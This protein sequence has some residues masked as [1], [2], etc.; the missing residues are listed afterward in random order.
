MKKIHVFLEH[1]VDNPILVNE[2]EHVRADVQPL[3]MEQNPLGCGN[4]DEGSDNSNSGSEI[5]AII[6]RIIIRITLR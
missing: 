1:P 6:M 2:G 4:N 3:A 5:I